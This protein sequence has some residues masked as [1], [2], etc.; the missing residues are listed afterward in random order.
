MLPYLPIDRFFTSLAKK[1][2]D[3]VI[4][5]I[6]SGNATDGTQGLKAIKKAGG[7]TFAQDATAKYNSM[8][9]SAIQEGAADHILPPAGIAAA[10]VNLGRTGPAAQPA[11][12]KKKQDPGGTEKDLERILA[13]VRKRTGVDFSHYK[14]STVK[15]RLYHR[16]LQCRSKTIRE[17][18]KLLEDKKS[19][20]A[21][22]L[23]QDFLIHVTGFFRDVE[24]FRYLKN[25][26]L[27]ELIRNAEPHKFLRIWVPACS[28]GE[29][30]YSIAMLVTEILDRSPA[31]IPVQIFA[32]DISAEAIRTAR[33]GEYSKSDLKNVGKKR[34]DRFFVKVND[35]YRVARELRE[36][37]VFAPHNL[38]SDPPFSRI[39]LVSCRNL[40]IYFDPAAQKKAVTAL[41]QALRPG[42][43]LLL[44]RSESIGASGA[45]FT[46]V[47]NRY[48]IYTRNKTSGAQ[49]FLELEP[50]RGRTAVHAHEQEFVKKLAAADSTKLDAAINAL[51]LSRFMPACAVINRSMEILQFRGSTSIY[52][53]HPPGKASLNILK[54]TRPEFALELPSAIHKVFKTGKEV[55]KPG[56]EIKVNSVF[57]TVSLDVIPLIAD[58]ND[59]LLLVVFSMCEQ[60][61]ERP[62][63]EDLK[64]GRRTKKL[65][66]ELSSLRA[67]MHALIEQQETANEQLQAA[68]EEIVSSNEE[69]QTV[70]E[71]L[72]TSKEEI[73]ASNEELLV[74]N[75]ELQ[76]RNDLLTESYNYSEAIINTIHEPL[77]VLDENLNVKSA[78]RSFYRKFQTTK[79]ETEGRPLFE[80]GNKQWRIPG[81]SELLEALISKNTDFH[82]F[83]VAH[84]FP[85]IGERILLLN[86]HR[87]VQKNHRKQ[88]ILLAI[89]DVTERSRHYLREKELLH[90]DIRVHKA[91]KEALEKAVTRRT[92]Q[93]E[94]KN[95]EL[96]RANKDLTSFTYVSSHDL[97]EPLRKIQNFVTCILLEE[98]KNLSDT[99]KS[100]FRRMGETAKRMQRLIEDL[101]NYSRVKSSE[102][103]PEDTDLGLLLEEV[104]KD[105]EEALD[106]KGAVVEFTPLGRA[107]V[108]VFQFR[109]L[110]YNLLSNSLKFSDPAVPLRIVIKSR[111][112]GPGK[113]RNKN[114][115]PK[116][117]Y[118]HLTFTDNG[119]GFDPQYR[120]RIFEVFQRLHSVE[121]YRGTGIGLAICK[122][123]VENHDGVITADGRPGKGA[124]FDI[125]I[126]L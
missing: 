25:V 66:E 79:E 110:F 60:A 17:Y 62:G 106:K 61:E 107:N 101:L 112:T 50:A 9:A 18:I 108:I 98:E 31:R 97:Q 49:Q 32:T 86:A 26:F 113:I 21:E 121:E 82:N 52:L 76:M 126:P 93:L 83:E 87:I 57:R 11:V 47:N 51:L 78:S 75:Q 59:P 41:H 29:E 91:D 67:E 73:E 44:G 118:L 116:M 119:I 56:I 43:F 6:L 45:F 3:K 12:A 30:A 13:V 70:N 115:S 22:H 95:K 48:N 104:I 68:N 4:G 94:Q 8:P 69:F 14:I 65:S 36:M 5:V 85:G 35:R 117:K 100:Y 123:I 105:F 10:I 23:Y 72:E 92:R 37:C 16:M 40:L 55:S 90:K 71:E 42:G 33:I 7:L 120:D 103:S 19:A 88:L 58:P 114:L 24:V 124:R 125:Y 64:S 20:E 54:M 34:I 2:K 109:Q 81:L 80:L 74:T 53:G 96:E 15:R 102:H 111:V 46:R 1:Y 84:T 63:A 99:G 89:E 122:K 28:T 39:D 38:L 27:P 77:I